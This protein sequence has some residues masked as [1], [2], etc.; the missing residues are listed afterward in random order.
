M[1]HSFERL[2]C[3]GLKALHKEIKFRSLRERLRGINS[4]RGLFECRSLR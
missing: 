4:P 3:G 1:L 2:L